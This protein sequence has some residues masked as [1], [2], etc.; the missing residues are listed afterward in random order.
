MG[1][2]LEVGV[3]GWELEVYTAW[4]SGTVLCVLA[5]LSLRGLLGMV[6]CDIA[7][8]FAGLLESSGWVKNVGF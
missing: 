7:A 8:G 5:V 6:H 3:L 2:G 4:L 1:C